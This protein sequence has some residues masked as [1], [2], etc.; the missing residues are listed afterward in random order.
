MVG[1][2]NGWGWKDKKMGGKK[3]VPVIY[4]LVT[5]LPVYFGH[6]SLCATTFDSIRPLDDGKWVKKLGG[7]KMKSSA[8]GS[9]ILFAGNANETLNRQLQFGTAVVVASH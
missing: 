6:F 8:R 1:Q 7:Q 3:M 4:F 9:Q 5:D 2:K